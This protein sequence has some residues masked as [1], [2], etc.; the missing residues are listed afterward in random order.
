[1][2]ARTRAR[3]AGRRHVG[4]GAREPAGLPAG[5]GRTAPPGR[6]HPAALAACQA[7]DLARAADGFLPDLLPAGHHGAVDR[8]L[9]DALLARRPVGGGRREPRYTASNFSRFTCS[10][11]RPSIRIS[12]VAATRVGA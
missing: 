9:H 7:N 5:A 8:D 3:E 6:T 11:L 4:R 2:F 1:R 10:M 12:F